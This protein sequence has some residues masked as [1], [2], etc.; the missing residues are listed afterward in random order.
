MLKVMKCVLVITEGHMK[1]DIYILNG[2]TNTRT[3]TIAMSST[4]KTSFW[5]QRLG[6]VSL[7]GMQI[8]SKQRVIGGDSIG[9]Q[10]FYRHYVYGKMHRV[11]FTT[12]Q[13]C[14]ILHP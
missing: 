9:D 13:H 10:P 5:Y 2:Y 1:N 3:A 7:K 6:H 11:R 14:T 8:L 12:N 4:N